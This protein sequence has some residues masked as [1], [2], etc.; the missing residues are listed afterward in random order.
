MLE[1]DASELATSNHTLEITGNPLCMAPSLGACRSRLLLSRGETSRMQRTSADDPL[2]A[3]AFCFSR[4]AGRPV[5][6]SGTIWEDVVRKTKRKQ[7]KTVLR[8]RAQ[9]MFSRNPVLGL[10]LGY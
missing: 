1:K 7:T 2:V 4:A 10:P 8:D 9:Q 6:Q 3:L 5:Q